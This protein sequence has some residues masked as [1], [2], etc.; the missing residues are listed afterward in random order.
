MHINYEITFLITVDG[1]EKLTSYTGEYPYNGSIVWMMGHIA[2]TYHYRNKDIRFVSYTVEE[3]HSS[4]E[5]VEV[6]DF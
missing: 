6:F 3:I 4:S 5:I 1:E 2:D